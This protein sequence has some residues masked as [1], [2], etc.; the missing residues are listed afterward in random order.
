MCGHYKLDK[1]VITL[2]KREVTA[3]EHDKK[4]PPSN[5]KGGKKNAS[6]KGAP[7]TGLGTTEPP[8]EEQ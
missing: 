6:R 4:Q 5:K 7:A 2:P 8:T 1:A 3:K